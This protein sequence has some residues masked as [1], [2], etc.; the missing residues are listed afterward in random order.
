M[1]VT[2]SILFRAIMFALL[3]RI[4]WRDFQTQRIANKDV[5]ALGLLGLAGLTLGAVADNSWWNWTVGAIAGAAMFIALLP[6][7]LLRKLGAG[8]VKLLA[9]VPLVTGGDYLFAFALLLLLFAALTAF[10]VKNP[11]LLPAPAFRHYLEHLERKGVVPFGVPISASLIGVLCL[12]S[13]R[14]S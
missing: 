2:A 5:L 8:D 13:L 12:A 9:T 11:V 3:L 10:L 7:W 6:F 4:A 14:V 1:L